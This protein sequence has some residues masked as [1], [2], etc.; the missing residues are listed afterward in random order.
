MSSSFFHF[1]LRESY[2]TSTC[3][4]NLQSDWANPW[5]LCTHFRTLAYLQR[6]RPRALRRRHRPTN[7]L[8]QQQPTAAKWN[9]NT[10]FQQVAKYADDVGQEY[11]CAIAGRSRTYHKLYEFVLWFLAFGFRLFF[12]WTVSDCDLH[13]IVTLRSHLFRVFWVTRNFNELHLQQRRICSLIC[14]MFALVV[15]LNAFYMLMNL[16]VL[17]GCWHVKK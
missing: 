16:W 9:T 17:R 7:Q 13:P 11:K 5:G 12:F 1:L 8:Q 4:R 15:V 3:Q 6:Q 10:N 2:S 14:S